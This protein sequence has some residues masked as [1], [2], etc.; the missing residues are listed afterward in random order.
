MMQAYM[1]E[2]TIIQTAQFDRVLKH[3]FFADEKRAQEYCER[4]TRLAKEADPEW[5]R[6]I[7][8]EVVYHKVY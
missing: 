5:A 1:W 8:T 4:E 2:V 7:E 3:R 6:Y